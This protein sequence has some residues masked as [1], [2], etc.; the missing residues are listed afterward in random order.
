MQCTR[1][2]VEIKSTVII[3]VDGEWRDDNAEC[4]YRNYMRGDA[5]VNTD[6]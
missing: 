2:Q 5:T 3:A 6:L 4:I 1:D